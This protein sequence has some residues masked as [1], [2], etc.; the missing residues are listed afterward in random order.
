MHLTKNILINSEILTN[1]QMEDGELKSSTIFLLSCD[2]LL[3][4]LQQSNEI[5]DF[6]IFET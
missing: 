2:S 6:H 4:A 1:M 3:I 5:F